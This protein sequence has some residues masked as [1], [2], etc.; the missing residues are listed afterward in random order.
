MTD[1]KHTPTPRLYGISGSDGTVEAF[2]ADRTFV[3]KVTDTDVGGAIVRAVN[4]H[5]ALVEALE[6]A[7]RFITNGIAFGYI[8][9]PD[10]SVGDPANETPKI[11][12]AALAQARGEA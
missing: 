2:T 4:S 9:L 7:D 5:D 10:E 11:I 8:R 12:R 1:T 6:R 3:A